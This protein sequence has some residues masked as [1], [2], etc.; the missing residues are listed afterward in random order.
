MARLPDSPLEIARRVGS[1]RTARPSIETPLA[2]PG[3]EIEKELMEIW[4]E[5]LKLIEIGINDNLFDLGGDSLHMTMI[6]SRVRQRMN[7]EVTFGNFFEDP[8]IKGLASAVR[9]L[10]QPA[11]GY[12]DKEAV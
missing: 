2:A 9:R 12:Q 8:T 5:V 7:V 11:N 4:C 10:N 3:D 6:A 1:T